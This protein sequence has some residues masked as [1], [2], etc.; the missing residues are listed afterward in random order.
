MKLKKII[1][2]IAIAFFTM[3]IAKSANAYTV[4][5]DDVSAEEGQEFTVNIKMDTNTPFANG[6]IK[7]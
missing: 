3:A 7:L 4:T 6:H 2:I 5:V 1:L